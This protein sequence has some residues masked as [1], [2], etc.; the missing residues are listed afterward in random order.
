MQQLM[1]QLMALVRFMFLGQPN[2]ALFEKIWALV[3]RSTTHFG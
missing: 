2:L 1:W 3:I